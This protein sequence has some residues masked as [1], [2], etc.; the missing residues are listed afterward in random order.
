AAL[1]DRTQGDAGAEEMTRLIHKYVYEDQPYEKAAKS[2]VNGAMRVNEGA[3]LNMD[4]IAD[5]LAWF[6]SEGLVKDAVSMEML[7]DDSYVD[8][9]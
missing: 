4:S 3:A 9:L 1:V 2:I 5:Q 6:K 8:T 7:V